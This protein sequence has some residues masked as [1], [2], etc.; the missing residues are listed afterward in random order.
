M[1]FGRRRAE[2]RIPDI[3]LKS[4][5]YL[6]ERI[7]EDSSASS[8][9][10][11]GT[12]FFI[13]VPSAVHSGR[14]YCAFV[15]AKHLLDDHK[16]R[17]L[18]LV[19][20]SRTGAPG[21]LALPSNVPWW[22]HPS[23]KTTDVALA[24]FNPD[25]ELDVIQIH[26]NEFLNAE[27]MVQ[28]HIGLG[29]EVFF[30]GLFVWAPGNDRMTPIVRHGNIA[31]VPDGQ[32]QVESSFA[33]VYLVEA[34]SLG[35]MSG[36][37]VF[38]VETIALRLNDDSVLRGSGMPYLLG[39]MHGHWDIKESDINLPHFSQDRKRGVNMGI[40]VVIPAT[41]ILDILNR[42]ELVAIRAATDAETSRSMSPGPDH[43]TFGGS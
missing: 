43:H 1:R 12:G 15:T 23:D 34:H 20:N 7:G 21:I 3:V 40:A 39:L 5:G 2:L 19:V 18:V 31:L 37:P 33:D 22:T 25:A 26:T 30:P 28:K 16:G 38:A 32:I 36:S 10:L 29:D 13:A 41:K 17:D 4:I 24:L 27:K 14:S 6:G 42:P 35:G 11:F 8:L 9:D